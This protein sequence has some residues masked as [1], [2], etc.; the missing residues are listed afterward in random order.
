VG[1]VQNGRS[2]LYGNGWLRTFNG[3]WIELQTA[4]FGIY[5]QLY[6]TGNHDVDVVGKMF[7]AETGGNTIND[8]PVNSI[9]KADAQGSRIVMERLE[10]LAGGQVILRWTNLPERTYTIYRTTDL[11]SGWSTRASGVSGGSFTDDFGDKKQMF[12]KVSEEP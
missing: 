6:S 10:I 12:W 9:L 4:K 8:T 7:R 3:E 2:C 5:K 11:M 1:T